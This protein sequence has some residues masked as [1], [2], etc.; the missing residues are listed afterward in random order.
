MSS[1]AEVKKKLELILPHEGKQVVT[2]FIHGVPGIGKSAIVKQIADERNIQFIDLRL[3]QHEASDIKGIPYP[4]P[5]NNVCK[6][7]PPEFLP[8]KTTKKFHGT[9]GILFLDEI[10]RAQPDV[11]QTVFQLVLDRRVGEL[12]LIDEWHIV[13]AGNLGDE[14]GTDV[15]DLDPALNNRF[16]HLWMEPDL[17]SW[18][19]WAKKNKIHSDIIGFIK[20]KPSYLYSVQKSKN[21]EEQFLVT[22]RSWEKFSRLIEANQHMEIEEIAKLIAPDI[23]GAVAIHFFRYLEE[24]NI[25]KPK[26]VLNSFETVED[27]ISKLSREQ[28][29]ALNHELVKYIAGLSR[30]TNKQLD[31]MHSYCTKFLEDDIHLAFMKEL[32][33]ETDGKNNFID[34]YIDKFEDECDRIVNVFSQSG[35]IK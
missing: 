32:A 8:F 3:S 33:K 30:I 12:E 20:S 10:N 9:K 25:I 26:D 22:P 21:S 16:I 11:L 4:D 14:D 17:N 23:I 19:D 13:A 28:I 6:W 7:L 31:N 24:R 5:E 2:P 34:R 15:I 29:H 18:L 1:P 27:R 35:E